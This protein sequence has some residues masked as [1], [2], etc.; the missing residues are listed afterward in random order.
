MI[1]VRDVFHC[2]YGKGGELAALFKEVSPLFA[3]HGYNPPKVMADLSGQFFTIVTEY[4][5]DSMTQWY[6][7]SRKLFALPEFG[8]WFQKMVPLV[9]DGS[10]E[11]YEYQ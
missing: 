6:E 1:K 2:K 11:F 3:R 7:A 4:D 9:E 5:F 10:R 8:P